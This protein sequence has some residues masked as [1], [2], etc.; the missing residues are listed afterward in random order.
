[1]KIHVGN[2]SKQVTDAKLNELGAAFG[3]PQ[4]AKVVM[5][6]SDNTSKGFGFIEFADETQARAA[7]TGLNGKDVDGQT[8]KVAEAHPPKN[9]PAFNARY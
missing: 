9:T 8:L 6:R 4:S 1:M 2:L 3:T 5:D 7:I